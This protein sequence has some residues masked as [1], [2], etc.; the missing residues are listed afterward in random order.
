MEKKLNKSFLAL[1]LISSITLFGFISMMILVLCDHKF[2]IDKF[3]NVVANNRN[4]FYNG[5]FKIFTYLGSFYTLLT[6][7]LVGVLIIWLVLK[8][9]RLCVF[10]ALCFGIVCGLNVIFKLIIRRMRPEH[11]M[12]IEEVGFSFPSGHAMMS[13]AFFLLLSHFVWK[14]IKNKPLKIT[15]I[16]LFMVLAIMIG[17]SRIYLGVHYFSDVLAGWLLT[18]TITFL[19]FVG[20]KSK[21]F[22]SKHKD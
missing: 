15:L 3:N 18:I 5:F 6:L 14:T 10:Y 17:F 20:Y 11:F 9:K 21:I 19:S 4:T 2:I 22:R 1:T 16:S 13:L 7:T 8:N 12:L